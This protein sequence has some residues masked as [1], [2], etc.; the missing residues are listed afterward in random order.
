MAITAEE[1][2]KIVAR[3]RRQGSDDALVEVKACQNSLSKDV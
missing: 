1:L 3:L 2:E